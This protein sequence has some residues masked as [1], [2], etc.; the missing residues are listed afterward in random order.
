MSVFVKLIAAT[1]EADKVVAAAAKIC[2]SPSGA[3]EIFDGLDPA[4][5]ASFLKMLREAG[6]LSPF[7][8]ASF[9]F[10][11]EGVS[12]VAT[13][14]LV[15][16]RM[17][18]YSQQS[19]RYVGMAGNGCIVPPSVEANPEA[20]AVFNEQ[21]EAAQR[22]YEK[23]VSLGVPKEDARFILPHGAETRIVV[24]MNAR[25][26]HH[27]F[28]LRLCRRAQ[29]E[30]RELAREMLRAAREAAPV[31]FGMAGPSCVAEGA[32]REAHSCGQPYKDMEDV[33]SR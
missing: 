2:Y 14:Q 29:W 1:P 28:A 11:I 19:Q 16:H 30:I 17:A 8:H 3:A 10:A 31:L 7:E 26:L 15:R 22:A 32:C 6:H 21:T 12:R 4:K 13:H 24:T 5:T 18:S 33:L 27:F 9:T 25:E 23:L 20:L